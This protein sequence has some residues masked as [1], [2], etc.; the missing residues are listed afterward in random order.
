MGVFA[1]RIGIDVDGILA[2]FF[3]AYEELMVEI[4]GVDRFPARYPAVLP[5]VWNWPQ[6]YGYSEQVVGEAWRRI[7]DDPT[8]WIR[9]GLLPG[10]K[11]FL[12]QLDQTDHEL[13]FI[14]DRPGTEPQLQTFAWLEMNGLHA[15]SVII[16]RKGK[17]V[18]CDALSID[19]YIDD[20]RENILDVV[21][22][23]PTTQVYL[24]SYPYN[25][26]PYPGSVRDIR[27]LGQFTEAIN[28]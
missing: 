12:A 25:N 3:S 20:K 18:V 8:F 15:P 27:S 21:D 4:D 9:L 24:L 7:K 11:E 17:G 10:A 28:G 2:D 22:K 26:G 13:Y 14:T 1:L 19:Y 16:S 6:H 23:S 5:P